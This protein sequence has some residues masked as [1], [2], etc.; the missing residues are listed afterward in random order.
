MR[1]SRY[2]EL[3]LAV[4]TSM[5]TLVPG[6]SSG[7]H[8]SNENNLIISDRIFEFS[9]LQKILEELFSRAQGVRFKSDNEVINLCLL[10]LMLD[11][12]L[13]EKYAGL[14]NVSF[15]Q[16]LQHETDTRELQVEVANLIY[17]SD[18]KN[19]SDSITRSQVEDLIFESS[20][21]FLVNKGFN[22][23]SR[24]FQ[25]I[26]DLNADPDYQ[27]Y[28]L[29]VKIYLSL[30]SINKSVEVDYYKIHC[31]GE[32]RIVIPLNFSKVTSRYLEQVTKQYTFSEEQGALV[33]DNLSVFDLT[34]Q[35]PE[36]NLYKIRFDSATEIQS[37]V[38]YMEFTN[39]FHVLGSEERYLAF[40]ADN[41]LSVDA[42][43]AERMV[44]LINKIEVEVATVFFNE[45]ISFVPCFKY[46]ESEDVVLFCSRNI[47]YMVDKAGQ[48]SVDYYGMRHELIE[49]IKSDELFI[50]ANDEHVFENLKLSELLTESK[51][52]FHYP[53]YLLQVSERKH[54]INLLDLAIQLR[55]VSFFT[56]VFFYLRRASVKLE[57]IGKENDVLKITGP[58]R[59]AMLYVLKPGTN[60]NAHYDDIF[61]KQF[62]DLNRLK[63]L[64][65]DAVS[66]VSSCVLNVDTLALTHF[67]QFIEVLSDNFTKYQ[68][69][70][71]GDYEIRPRQKQKDFLK[72]IICSETPMH[73]RCVWGCCIVCFVIAV[74]WCVC[75]GNEE[76]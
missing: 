58:W 38:K 75:S 74:W 70:T 53:D 57:Y 45:A 5:D 42:S 54:L 13:Y 30:C 65:L 20:Y 9:F 6:V 25:L 2:T 76:Q 67:S 26:R 15:L 51:N 50:D 14:L 43:N 41:V 64:P 29:L 11:F 1:A 21:K 35:Q 19:T 47:H 31:D 18:R 66:D 48:M 62:F 44:I 68:R 72:R 69:W 49:N 46:S 61:K 16:C 63:D 37:M 10:S 32:F 27:S 73:F 71:D 60:K 56:L 36:I 28:V 55:N 22:T 12:G 33:Y 17:E 52:V 4:A 7:K 34:P 39:T 59:E 3:D 23:R 24:Q 8:R 40:M